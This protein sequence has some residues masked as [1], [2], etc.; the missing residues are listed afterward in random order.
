[1]SDAYM[2]GTVG[3][4]TTHPCG[5]SQRRE[6]ERGQART[7]TLLSALSSFVEPPAR[8]EPRAPSDAAVAVHHDS[9]ALLLRVPHGMPD[10]APAQWEHIGVLSHREGERGTRRSAVSLSSPVEQPARGEPKAPSNAANQHSCFLCH[11]VC[12]TH[13]RH[14]GSTRDTSVCFHSER[15]SEG[16]DPAVSLSR[17]LCGTA[18]T[19]GE[20]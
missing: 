9:S 4:H 13:D 6:G 11:A 10:A 15:A 16:L 14:S 7:E 20:P 17:L 18:Y 3:A 19:R 5:L 12:L 8:G 2:N 1:M